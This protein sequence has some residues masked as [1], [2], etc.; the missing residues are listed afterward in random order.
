MSRMMVGVRAACN[1]LIVSSAIALS[2]TIFIGCT[3]MKEK[4]NEAKE[5]HET[6]Q[7]KRREAK[8]K[9]Y[10]RLAS[11]P[12]AQVVVQTPSREIAVCAQQ[13]CDLF[14]VAQPKMRA[15]IDLTENSYE[16]RGYVNDVQYY[17]EEEKMSSADAQK[18]VMDAVIAG[19]ANRPD[20]EKVWP[21]IVKGAE[22]ARQFGSEA[23]GKQFL[24]LNIR[25]LEIN[26]RIV[27]ICKGLYDRQKELK[28]LVKHKQISKEQ[29]QQENS[30]ILQRLAE[31]AAVQQQLSDAGKCISFMVEQHNRV[32]ELEN[33]AAR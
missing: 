3:T 21:K 32:R 13:S 20:G 7:L 8:E 15:Y 23:E 25:Y 26:A 22:A 1:L 2:V 27:K 12:P 9:E 33:E 18:K 24:G 29:M 11:L 10:K 31:C 19:D 16:Y 28:K 14:N 4:W 17:I 5:W 30:V 6:Q